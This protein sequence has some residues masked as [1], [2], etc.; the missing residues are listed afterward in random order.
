MESKSHQKL[1]DQ[2]R[3]IPLKKI[4]YFKRRILEWYKIYRRD[5]PW[6]NTDDPFRIIIAEILLQQ[7][8]AEKVV[9]VYNDF[10]ARFPSPSALSVARPSHV[11]QYISRIG[12]NYKTMRLITIAKIINDNYDGLI[13]SSE[14]EIRK[15]PGV[16]KYITNALLCNAFHKKLA[17]LD[18]NIIRIINRYF[19]ISS[20]R[21]R[22]R[23][24]PQLWE[25]AKYLL[26]RNSSKCRIWNYSILD[27]CALV[28]K[29]YRPACDKCTC[30]SYC[31]YGYML[32]AN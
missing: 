6:R 12:L 16:G 11:Q 1:I 22:P 9:P 7:T 18:T 28:C 13:P 5:F 8:N 10:I 24:D 31:D 20:K 3:L 14:I 17:L 2:F 23:T 21:K 32:H 30:F 29:H 4:T 15:L 26:P 19:S 27:Y 25:V